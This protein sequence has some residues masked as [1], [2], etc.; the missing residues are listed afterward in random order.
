MPVL[1]RELDIELVKQA[2][3]AKGYGPSSG[4]GYAVTFN[5]PTGR[6][7]SNGSAER[8]PVKGITETQCRQILRF[9]E[10][11]EEAAA[12]FERVMLGGEILAQA[13]ANFKAQV[14][15]SGLSAAEVDS[16]VSARVATEVARLFAEHTAQVSG[17]LAEVRKEIVDL[18]RDVGKLQ[19]AAHKK[20]GRPLGSKN[21][22]KP[23][24]DDAP[25]EFPGLPALD[26]EGIPKQF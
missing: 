16:L 12:Q 19:A 17:W 13:S 11:V 21:K 2:L 5:K 22:T 20:A 3:Y 18:R 9:S 6:V 23:A 26:Q 15:D 1:F 24:G 4:D 25:M 14:S 7:F 10:T 8:K